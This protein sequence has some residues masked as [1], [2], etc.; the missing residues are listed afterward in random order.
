MD[1]LRR[2]HRP[3]GHVAFIPIYVRDFVCHFTQVLQCDLLSDIGCRNSLNLILSQDFRG[4]PDYLLQRKTEF[5]SSFFCSRFLS[6]LHLVLFCGL[7][8]RNLFH[9]AFTL[10]GPAVPFHLRTGIQTPR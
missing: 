5:C 1:P 9:D 2:Q 3:A 10:Y 6:L 8:L 4:I 7:I